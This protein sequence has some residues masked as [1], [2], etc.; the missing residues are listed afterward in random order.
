MVKAGPAQCGGCR[1]P[2]DKPEDDGWK[3]ETL[4]THRLET[5]RPFRPLAPQ[6]AIPAAT[7][8]PKAAGAHPTSR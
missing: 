4:E 1:G 5:S 7:Q 2:R 8:P 6:P 3:S